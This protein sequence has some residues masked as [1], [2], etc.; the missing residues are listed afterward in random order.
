MS[1]IGKVPIAIPAGVEVTLNGNDVAVKGPN[2]NFAITEDC[3]GVFGLYQEFTGKYRQCMA[4]A[5]S[6]AK[7]ANMCVALANY[8]PA[9]CYADT[10]GFDEATTRPEALKCLVENLCGPEMLC[11]FFDKLFRLENVRQGFEETVK[12]TCELGG[13]SYDTLR[14]VDYAA[15]DCGDETTDGVS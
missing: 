13:V 8:V 11:G 10:F 5:D 3:Q 9:E 6:V 2:K 12:K 15:D 7:H 14:C 1:R 4:L